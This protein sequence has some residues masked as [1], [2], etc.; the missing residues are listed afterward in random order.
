VTLDVSGA[1]IG[2]SGRM[3]ETPVMVA[4]GPQPGLA[5]EGRRS[6]VGGGSG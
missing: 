5:G 3:I 1:Q 6:R 4:G 2:A